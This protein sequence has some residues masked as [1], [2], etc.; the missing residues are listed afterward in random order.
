MY[1]LYGLPELL[2]PE[3]SVE[4]AGHDSLPLSLLTELV[5][6]EPLEGVPELLP[7]EGRLLWQRVRAIRVLRGRV[8]LVDQIRTVL[9]GCHISLILNILILSPVEVSRKV[10]LW[11]SEHCSTFVDFQEWLSRL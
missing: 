5:I 6:A 3:M 7:V 11:L 2:L 4:P 1:I 10:H 9:V 8:D